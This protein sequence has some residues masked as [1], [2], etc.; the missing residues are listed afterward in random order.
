MGKRNRGFLGTAFAT[1]CLSFSMFASCPD[2]ACAAEPAT[3]KVKLVIVDNADWQSDGS[4]SGA[5]EG[6]TVR[7]TNCKVGGSGDTIALAADGSALLENI[8]ASQCDISAPAGLTELTITGSA[9]LRTEAT[10]RD[11]AGNFNTV[12][13]PAFSPD[14]AA[15]GKTALAFSRI[16]NAGSRS[17]YFALFT[18]SP[19][20]ATVTIYDA[21]NKRLATEPHL[22]ARFGFYPIAQSVT[23]GRAEVT[24]GLTN[25]GCDGCQGG[26]PVYGVAFVGRAA[27]GSP[28][29]EIPTQRQTP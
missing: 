24:Q 13:I 25:F 22:V 26:A 17:S 28:R 19:T 12:D 29:V 15:S 2:V 5:T 20:W 10:Y 8:G 6:T 21:A 14:L 23:I 9:T 18:D 16:E 1:L 11:A 4:I 27:G 7:K 3:T